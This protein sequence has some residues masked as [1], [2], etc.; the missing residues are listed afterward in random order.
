MVDRLSER[1]TI[2]QDVQS[3]ILPTTEK[4]TYE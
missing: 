2:A 3:Q 1:Y 4:Q